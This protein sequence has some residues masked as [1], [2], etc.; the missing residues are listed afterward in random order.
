MMGPLDT[1]LALLQ[2]P[3]VAAYSKKKEYERLFR[4]LRER[5]HLEREADLVRV[6]VAHAG[7]TAEDAEVRTLAAQ[8]LA[9]LAKGADLS[10]ISLKRIR[11]CALAALQE[12]LAQEGNLKEHPARGAYANVLAPLGPRCDELPGLGQEL[13][14]PLCAV[15]RKTRELGSTMVR[16]QALLLLLHMLASDA[17]RAAVRAA[18]PQWLE[19]LGLELRS[20]RDGRHCEV[21]S[22]AIRAILILSLG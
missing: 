14:A 19:D 7:G 13:T 5:K 16:R 2:S 12:A 17:H 11:Q 3:A 6:C 4:D 9:V 8:C 15:L 1:M 21:R 20:E 18:A 10:Q 22:R